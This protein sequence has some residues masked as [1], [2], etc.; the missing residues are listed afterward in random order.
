M[1][2]Q[3]EGFHLLLWLSSIYLQMYMHPYVHCS[4]IYSGQDMETIKVFF[5]I[6]LRKEDVVNIYNGH[7][8]FQTSFFSSFCFNWLIFCCHWPLL[9]NFELYST[10]WVDF[11]VSFYG[12]TMSKILQRRYFQYL[13]D[14][15]RS[16]LLLWWN[17]EI[18]LS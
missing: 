3:M 17:S 6:W 13:S 15:D 18:W 10:F 11:N 1:L 5:T 7:Y 9:P 8:P 16:M 12:K 2:S 4:I 14:P